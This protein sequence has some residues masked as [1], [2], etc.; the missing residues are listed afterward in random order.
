M[1]R[2]IEITRN[3]FGR[4][5]FVFFFVSEVF[6]KAVCQ[7]SP[8]FAYADRFTKR[9]GYAIDDIYGDAWKVVSDFSRSIGS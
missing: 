9:A 3:W 7:S 5:C 2:K 6:A 8:R 1:V 4:S